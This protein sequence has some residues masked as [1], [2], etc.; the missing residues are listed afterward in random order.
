MMGITVGVGGVGSLLGTAL[1][2][3]LVRRFGVGRTILL[4]FLISAISAV[5]VPAAGGPLALKV[6][7]LMVAQLVGDSM[8]VAAMIPTA[9]LRQSVIPRDMLGRTAALMSVGSGASAVMGALLGGTLGS[10]IGPRPALFAAV[11]GLIAT[12]LTGFI[13]P[14]WRL[15]EIPAAEPK[16]P[17]QGP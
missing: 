3:P 7:S 11:A 6:A 10:T 17:L 13:S 2:A 4:G 14:L 15:Q 16:S 9:S 12:P 8:A 1:S 5:F